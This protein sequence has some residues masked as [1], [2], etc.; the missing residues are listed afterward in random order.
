MTCLETGRTMVTRRLGCLSLAG[1]IQ[2]LCLPTCKPHRISGPYSLPGGKEVLQS[3][4][5]FINTPPGQAARIAPAPSG[6]TTRVPAWNRHQWWSNRRRSHRLRSSAHLYWNLTMDQQ[7]PWNSL[8]DIAY[9]G[10]S[11]SQMTNMGESS[12]GSSFNAIADQNKTPVGGLF[13]PDPATGLV[14]TNPENVSHDVRRHRLQPICG[15]SSVGFCLRHQ[16]GVHAPVEF[17]LQLQCTASSSG[18]NVLAGSSL[19]STSL[20]RSNWEPQ[21]CRSIPSYSAPTTAC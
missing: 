6:R 9:V 3:Q 8:L 5:G 1:S 15:L 2:R 20:G 12:N 21:H 7:L 13:A 4:I 10:S 18:Q 17:L 16:L 19:T 14:A 11:S